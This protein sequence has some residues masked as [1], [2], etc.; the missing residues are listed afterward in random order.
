MCLFVTQRASTGLQV[1]H[2]LAR[3]SPIVLRVNEFRPM[4]AI[5]A[6]TVIDGRVRERDMCGCAV[7]PVSADIR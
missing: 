5:V 2:R 1:T 3:N 6:R 4:R 7:T